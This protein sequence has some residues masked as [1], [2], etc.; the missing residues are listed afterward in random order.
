MNP[1]MVISVSTLTAI[2]AVNAAYEIRRRR[3]QQRAREQARLE[4][5]EETLRQQVRA[6][7]R[8]GL[9]L[10]VQG[11]FSALGRDQFLARF[12]SLHPELQ[13]ATGQKGGA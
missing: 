2:L 3:R 4:L 6:E 5:L 8:R 13:P 7:Q 12:L 1:E 10:T 11:E 9:R